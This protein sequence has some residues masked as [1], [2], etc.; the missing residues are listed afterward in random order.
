MTI[1]IVC[2]C[3]GAVCLYLILDDG[4]EEEDPAGLLYGLPI[5]VIALALFA[6]VLSGRLRWAVPAV[7]ASFVSFVLWA[8]L[9]VLYAG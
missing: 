1:S 4:P 8:A 2:A 9:I 6:F 7:T 3:L 5:A